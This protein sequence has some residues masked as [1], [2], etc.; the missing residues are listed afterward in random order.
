MMFVNNTGF[1]FELAPQLD[2]MVI[3]AEHRYYGTSKPDDGV[4]NGTTMGYLSSL[5]ALA[6]FNDL[7]YYLKKV[8]PG[9]QKSPVVAFGGSYGGMLAA[10]MST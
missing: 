8:V 2:A 9:A 1:M 5:Q 4:L 3:F 6:D 7:I 10:W